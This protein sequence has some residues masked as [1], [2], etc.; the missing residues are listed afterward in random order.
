MKHV[1]ARFLKYLK[2]RQ[3]QTFTSLSAVTQ[4]EFTPLLQEF[5]VTKQ[6]SFQHLT[7]DVKAFM[8]LYYW[9]DGQKFRVPHLDYGLFGTF[10]YEGQYTSL[11]MLNM[12][13]CNT[14]TLHGF[15]L[16]PFAACPRSGK[17]LS[18]CVNEDGRGTEWYGH[19]LEV[20]DIDGAF[21]DHGA[22]MQWF[23]DYVTELE[24]LHHQSVGFAHNVLN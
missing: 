13:V 3:P 23:S 8:L 24:Q 14:V 15:R 5:I 6:L 17:M 7:D 11:N 1:V 9:I 2:E 12:K 10:A 16:L 20:S 21:V 4:F 18:V 19:V 22:F